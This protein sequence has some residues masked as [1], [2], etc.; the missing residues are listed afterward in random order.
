MHIHLLSFKYTRNLSPFGVIVECYKNSSG[1]NCLKAFLY[2]YGSAEESN[3]LRVN[4]I[5][6]QVNNC[7]GYEKK[8]S[9]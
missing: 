3:N 9:L 5:S 8:I 7:F 1:K 4:I 6:F 2:Q